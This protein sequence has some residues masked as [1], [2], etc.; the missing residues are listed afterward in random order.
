MDL[1]KIST[2]ELKAKRDKLAQPQQT[3][4]TRLPTEQLKD[5]KRFVAKKNVERLQIEKEITKFGVKNIVRDI[6][7]F[8]P[9]IGGYMDNIEAIATSKIRGTDTKFE[10][11]KI[12]ANQRAYGRLVKEQGLGLGRALGKM[13]GGIGAGLKV[14]ALGKSKIGR[15][16]H[17]ILEGTIEGA[18]FGDERP[19]AGGLIGGSV[20]GI[21]QATF[22][23]L[24][25]RT[26]NEVADVSGSAREI[27]GNDK[28]TRIAIKGI[29]SGQ[30]TAK[31]INQAVDVALEGNHKAVSQT[32]TDSI[33][34]DL[35]NIPQ[36]TK[37]SKKGFGDFMERFGKNKV[38]VPDDFKKLALRVRKS[39]RDEVLPSHKAL[40]F[41]AQN[42]GKEV[43][44][45]ATPKARVGFEVRAEVPQFTKKFKFLD[46]KGNVL[47]EIKATGKESL[48]TAKD[49]LGL[50]GAS[51][52][53]E[54][55]IKPERVIRGRVGKFIKKAEVPKKL[56]KL[57]TGE[58]IVFA[59]KGMDL[60]PTGKRVFKKALLD[61]QSDTGEDVLTLNTINTAKRKLDDIINFNIKADTTSTNRVIKDTKNKLNQFMRDNFTGFE[62]VQFDRAEAF[63]LEEAYRQ[64]YKFSPNSKKGTLN[65]F[66][67]QGSEI[68]FK[69]WDGAQKEAFKQGAKD[70]LVREV[71]SKG[72][73]TNVAQSLT[74]MKDYLNEIF[75]D[76]EAQV[77]IERLRR[78]SKIF[79]NLTSMSSKSR[80]K[81]QARGSLG[82]LLKQN[83]KAKNI[84]A[85]AIGTAVGSPVLGAS[86]FGAQVVGGALE[87][88]HSSRTANLLFKGVKPEQFKDLSKS[89]TSGRLAVEQIRKK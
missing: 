84:V 81:L 82:S 32:I 20:A 66:T 13:S 42:V 68:P 89:L 3:N 18:G 36:I 75:P 80:N 56:T 4:L 79:K 78:D 76:G 58:K 65:L 9:F 35:L 52:V 15:I 46:S 25:S 11:A 31:N 30:R 5:L 16:A 8:V 73:G 39:A 28:A 71:S 59:Q 12:R 43:I 23:A 47:R 70:N 2:E 45:E 67:E 77:L 6:T 69:K 64:G 17:A 83:L 87:K 48:Q 21:I 10:L 53:V 44:E 33:G 62:E 37:E 50:F 40:G 26:A 7:E 57:T 63:R 85:P 74:S 86:I 27:A 54:E 60:T 51:K 61:A 22:G 19:L 88:A 41:T 24:P 14:P 34:E 38:E 72:E 55:S 29:D 49:N 1:S